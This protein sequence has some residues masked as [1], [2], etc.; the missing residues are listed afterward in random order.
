MY[1]KV[2][3]YIMFLILI[4]GVTWAYYDQL[5][6]VPPSACFLEYS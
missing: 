1:V 2:P 4:C 3:L 6:Y 5:A